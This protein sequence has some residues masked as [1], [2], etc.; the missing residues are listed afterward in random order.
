MQAAQVRVLAFLLH[1]VAIAGIVREAFA[2]R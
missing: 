1:G 2:V